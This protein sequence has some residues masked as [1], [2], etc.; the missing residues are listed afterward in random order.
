LDGGDYG[1]IVSNTANRTAGRVGTMEETTITIL[2]V[3]AIAASALFVLRMLAMMIFGAGHGGDFHDG[4]AGGGGHVHIGAGESHSPDL[5]AHGT[6]S[7]HSETGHDSGHDLKLISTYTITAFL[8]TGAWTALA[9]HN[10]FKY[11]LP[12]S[13]AIGGG[14][15][16]AFMYLVAFMLSRVSVLEEDGTLR[17]FDPRGLRGEVYARVPASGKGEGQIRLQVKGRL[18]IF[19]AVSEEESPIESF[20]AVLITGMTGDQIMRVKRTE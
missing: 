1:N 17:N 7:A 3:I 13:I 6:G 4:D 12:L 9:C 20:S 5:G 11:D 19:R 2:W 14:V 16:F 10:A 18:R 8:M 15:G